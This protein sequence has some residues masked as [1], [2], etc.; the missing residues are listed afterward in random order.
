MV[1]LGFM[2]LGKRLELMAFEMESRINRRTTVLK[3]RN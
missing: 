1:E 3:L 2:F